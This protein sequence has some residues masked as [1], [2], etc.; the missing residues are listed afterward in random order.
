MLRG[1]AAAAITAVSLTLLGGCAS[2]PSSSTAAGTH[3][4]EAMTV[5][6][7]WQLTSWAGGDA[8]PLPQVRPVTL[9]FHDGK[10]SGTGGCNRLFG[11]Y[12]TGPG[13][14]L[15]ISPPASTRMACTDDDTMAFEASFLALL[16]QL[17]QFE[18]TATS[19]ILTSAAGDRLVFGPQVSPNDEF[20]ANHT[21]GPA[22]PEEREIDVDSH[23]SNCSGVGAHQ[24]LRVRSDA[25]HPWELWY[26]PIN[27]FVWQPG[28]KYRLRIRGEPVAHAAADASTMRWTLVEVLRRS[29]AG[30]AQ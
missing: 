29:P 24:C 26:A 20:T 27:G 6:G 16:P 12:K 10:L 17:N 5:E 22:Q 18:R 28:V 4:K 11:T 7:N 2:T 19:L 14:R 15:T 9:G 21:A 23:L 30:S 25:A 8:R 3:A 1:L 13:H